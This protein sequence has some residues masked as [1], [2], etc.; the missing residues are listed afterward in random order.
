MLV[1]ANNSSDPFSFHLYFPELHERQVMPNLERLKKRKI[2]RLQVTL[3]STYI[4]I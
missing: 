1:K 4:L 2:I 3:V